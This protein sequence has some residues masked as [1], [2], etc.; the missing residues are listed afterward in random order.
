MFVNELQ[1]ITDD[2]VKESNSSMEPLEL[3]KPFIEAL[4]KDLIRPNWHK[5]YKLL[6]VD[7]E[8]LK[9]IAVLFIETEQEVLGMHLL[10]E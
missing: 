6:V 2:Y 1:T 4:F 9:N 5:K 7:L 3:W 8:Y 10:S